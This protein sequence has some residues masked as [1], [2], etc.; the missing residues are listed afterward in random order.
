M[1][2][3]ASSILLQIFNETD[4]FKQDD[5]IQEFNQKARDFITARRQLV[6]MRLTE[7]E[8][9]ILDY[10]HQLVS[11]CCY[12]FIMKNHIS[13]SRELIR[14]LLQHLNNLICTTY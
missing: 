1:Q 11:A 4:E 13:I 12:R 9:K 6:T 8:R 5:F 3:S 7:A 10:Q 2:T 14:K